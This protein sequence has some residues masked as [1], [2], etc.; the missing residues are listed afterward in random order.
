M[1]ISK[2]PTFDRPP[3]PAWI[4]RLIETRFKKLADRLEQLAKKPALKD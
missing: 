1:D 2:P 4:D 3:V